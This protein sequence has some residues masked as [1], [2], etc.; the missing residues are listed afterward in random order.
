M[1]VVN[2]SSEKFTFIIVG[3][4]GMGKR[5]GAKGAWS[6]PVLRGTTNNTLRL[7]EC[8]T[9]FRGLWALKWAWQTFFWV[10]R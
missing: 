8:V 2:F 10:N 9:G 7:I 6:Q 4:N 1:R 3:G 5:G